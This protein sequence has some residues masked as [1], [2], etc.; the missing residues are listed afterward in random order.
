MEAYA[1]YNKS[2]H[3]VALVGNWVEE[4][5]L[6]A[7][8]GVFR[9]K[10]RA[11]PPLP[12]VVLS[13]PPKKRSPFP[14][15]PTTRPPIRAS[16]VGSVGR[17]TRACPLVLSPPPPPSHVRS[18]VPSRSLARSG[19]GQT[20]SA[21]DESVYAEPVGAPSPLKTRPRW[22]TTPHVWNPTIGGRLREVFDPPSTRAGIYADR[23]ALGPR[24][25]PRSR[26]WRLPRRRHPPNAP[27][28]S[29][30][31]HRRGSPRRR[32]RL[33]RPGHPPFPWARG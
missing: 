12:R 16:C 20:R 13:R 21:E 22:S 3:R 5:A 30:S 33:A 26:R 9:Y 31:L 11:D 23:A 1:N 8:T 4:R 18:P 25:A 6:E 29:T 27:P 7:D 24:T 10:V 28:I 14:S 32:P 2:T 15:H 17:S 19:V